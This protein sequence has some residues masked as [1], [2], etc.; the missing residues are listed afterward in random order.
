MCCCS[1][2]FSSADN[3]LFSVADISRTIQVFDIKTVLKE[4]RE[5]HYPLAK[6]DCNAKIS[7]LMSS[8]MVNSGYDGS[9][10]VW[11]INK[12]KIWNL[13]MANSVMTIKPYF[14]VC[15]VNFGFTKNELA[16]GSAGSEDNR[17]YVYYKMANRPVLCYDVD[18]TQNIATGIDAN[19]PSFENDSEVFVSAVAWRPVSELL[20]LFSKIYKVYLLNDSLL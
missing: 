14:V 12:V 6:M 10:T 1:L 17:A 5:F 15:T 2:E 19:S 13:N 7:P 8:I 3:S 18:S 16:V 11:D 20:L 9:V 4:P